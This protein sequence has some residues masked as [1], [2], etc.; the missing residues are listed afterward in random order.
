MIWFHNTSWSNNLNA[1]GQN[2]MKV[3]YSV[4]EF[5]QTVILKDIRYVRFLSGLG[6]NRHL[7][8]ASK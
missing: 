8:V 3:L 4:Y 2:F 1:N 6:F 5:L 7:K